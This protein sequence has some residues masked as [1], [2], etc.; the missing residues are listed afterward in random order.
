MP[1]LD[2]RTQ[3]CSPMR[4]TLHPRGREHVTYAHTL[5]H[6]HGHWNAHVSIGA[7]AY[8]H[9]SSHT[10]RTPCRLNGPANS[11][12]FTRN[13]TVATPKPHTL[14][15]TAHSNPLT[16]Y[17]IHTRNARACAAISCIPQLL[18]GHVVSVVSLDSANVATSSGSSLQPAPRPIA[19]ITRDPLWEGSENR[20]SAAHRSIA[21]FWHSTR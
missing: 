14:A 19:V 6:A 4:Y 13:P 15:H 11:I 21:K 17:H 20:P 3:M 16:P 5:T 7:L 1:A 8:T 2:M 9:Y 12:A 18:Q 10:P